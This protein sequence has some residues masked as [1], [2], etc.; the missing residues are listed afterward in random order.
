MFLLVALAVFATPALLFAHARLLRS[1]PSDKAR[2]SVPPTSLGLWFS[3]K[4][5]LRFTSILLTDSA[6]SSIPLGPVAAT[7]S[8]GV[9]VP[10]AGIIVGGQYKVSWRTAA[11]DGHATSGTFS[12]SVAGQPAPIVTV[13]IDSGQNRKAVANPV[14]APTQITPFST[15]MRWAEL[16]AI[17]T[18]IGI[19]AF[20]LAVISQAHLAS[21]IVA[22]INDRS[23]RLGRA[24]V[25]LFG[26]ATLSRALAQTE[27]MSNGGGSRFSALMNLVQHTGWGL[28]WAIGAIGAVLALLGLLVAGRVFGGWIAAALGVVAIAVSEALTGHAGA[29][30]NHYALFIATDVSHVLGA[31]AWLG[32]LTAL[33]L[34]G[35]PS[36]KRLDGPSAASAGSKLLRSFHS[37]SVEAVIVVV[38]SAIIAAWLRLPSFSALWTTPYGT[39]LFRKIVFVLMV[40]AFGFYHWRRIVLRPWTGDTLR[41]FRLSTIG[42][43]IVGA[44]VVAFTA[45]LVSQQLP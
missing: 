42:E 30:R 19:V 28:G 5:E 32:G 3:E 11:S 31:G 10:I 7:D 25:V 22:E 43:L 29:S 38:A 44:I 37:T 17:L 1:S 21:D 20:R 18:L 6:G 8:M 15:G 33:L 36:V 24:V 39:T 27:L 16:V 35:L 13:T 34:C 12:F 40:M 45:I 2:L 9:S 14:F 41:R 23:L 26:V 4:P